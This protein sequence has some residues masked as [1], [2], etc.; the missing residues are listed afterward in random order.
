MIAAVTALIAVLA[1]AVLWRRK[2]APTP[3]KFVL[4]PAK[5]PKAP[6]SKELTSPEKT[7]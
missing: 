5:P 7:S 1:I 2:K 3:A 4:A 6:E